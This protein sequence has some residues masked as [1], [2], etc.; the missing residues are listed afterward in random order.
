MSCRPK[1]EVALESIQKFCKSDSDDDPSRQKTKQDLLQS[2]ERCAEYRK[3]HG[4]KTL[5]PA[6]LSSSCNSVMEGLPDGIVDVV[7]SDSPYNMGADASWDSP[8][9]G[10]FIQSIKY[11]PTVLSFG[12]LPPRHPL[13]CTFF[14]RNAEHSGRYGLRVAKVAPSAQNGLRLAQ[15]VRILAD[16]GIGFAFTNDQYLSHWWLALESA[17]GKLGVP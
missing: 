16:D 2:L 15:F 12:A 17:A 8:G 3:K 4:D 9:H 6:V 1:I 13:M 14:I 10:K 7:L 5:I 11:S